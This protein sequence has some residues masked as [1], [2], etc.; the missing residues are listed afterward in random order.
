MERKNPRVVGLTADDPPL[1]DFAGIEVLEVN[2]RMIK[3]FYEHVFPRRE[4]LKVFDNLTAN[5]L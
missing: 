4:R 3:N 5:C 1:S 2:F